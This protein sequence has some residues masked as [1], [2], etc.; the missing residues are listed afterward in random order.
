MR[1][2]DFEAC[3]QA[4]EGPATEVAAVIAAPARKLRLEQLSML[5]LLVSSVKARQVKLNNGAWS[6]TWASKDV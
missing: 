4:A 5:L 6:L 2:G 3:D 1:K